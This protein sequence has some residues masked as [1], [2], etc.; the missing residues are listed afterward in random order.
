MKSNTSAG[1]FS[2]NHPLLHKA[3]W[4]RDYTASIFLCIKNQESYTHLENMYNCCIATY[5]KERTMFDLDKQIKEVTT[6]VKKYNEM[7][8]NWTI[9]V[10]EQFKK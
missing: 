2:C 1:I 8:I 6:Q 10:L 9:T 4:T 3:L 5:S 7:W